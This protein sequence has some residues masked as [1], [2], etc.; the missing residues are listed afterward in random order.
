M[1]GIDLLREFGE[2]RSEAAFSEVVR[3]F[4]NLVYSVAHRRLGNQSLAQEVAQTVFIR[5]AES[6][7]KLHSDAELMGWL[8]RTTVHVSIDL[9]RSESRRRAREEQASAMQL[10]PHEDPSWK[11]IAPALDEAIN[12]LSDTDQQAILLRFFQDKSMR[13]L[14]GAIGITEDAAKMRVSRALERLRD[15]LSARGVTCTAVALGA[16]LLEHSMEAA[17]AEVSAAIAA[18]SYPMGAN[19]AATGTGAA[20]AALGAAKLAAGVAALILVGVSAWLVMG[21]PHA[22]KPISVGLA[23]SGALP[24]TN[25]P[26]AAPQDAKPA[27]DTAS[28]D[29]A[30]LLQAVIRARQGIASGSF[31]F[32]IE[33]FHIP[34]RETNQSRVAAV[35]DGAKRRFEQTRREYAYTYDPDPVKAEEIQAKADAFGADREAAIR[36]GLLSG[37]EAH[38]VSIYDGSALLHYRETD[39]KPESATVDDV[40]KGGSQFVFDPRCLG[41]RPSLSRASLED[42]YARVSGRSVQ[43]LDQELVAGSATWHLRVLMEQPLDLWLDLA[44]PTWV[45]KVQAGSSIATSRYEASAAGSSAIPV[46]VIHTD[47]REGGPAFGT[48][49]LQTASQL[50]TTVAPETFTLSGLGMK[51]GTSVSDIRIHRRIGYWTGTGLSENLPD[52]KSAAAEDQPSLEGML[53]VLDDN[54]PGSDAAFN[55][56]EWILLNTPD[57]PAVEKAAAVILREHVRRPDLASLCQGMAR[58]RHRCVG[59]LLGAILKE[60]P[61]REVRAVACFTLATLRKAACKYGQD[62]QLTAE[63]E[64]LFGQVISEFSQAGPIGADLSTKAR[65]ELSEL[66]R[67][68]IGKAAPDF[69][70]TDLQGQRLKLSEQRGKPVIVV[71]W[72]RSTFSNLDE[73]RHPLS[74]LDGSKFFWLGVY[75]ENRVGQG[76]DEF[77]KHEVPGPAI[78]DGRSGPIAQA[79][80]VQSW[81]TVFVLDRNGVIRARDSRGGDLTDAVKA[82]LAE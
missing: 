32:N 59:E 64:K 60:N 27:V 29:P 39:G 55:A 67:L 72:S 38:D 57:G 33:A 58:M 9:W 28:P 6:V 54:D 63:A 7:P 73:H 70:G 61:E 71:F 36:A 81:P 47:S 82:L 30:Q 80:N 21:R 22:G 46:E 75:C 74:A 18:Y 41:L 56:A 35:F 10:N 19:V 42:W 26:S 53:A 14:G 1:N 25:S 45:L 62:K 44:H 50:N 77:G 34:Q 79:W 2:K 24:A 52:K 48:H 4:T 68:T 5:L 31:N 13:E 49:L 37:F 15:Q 51:I 69:E 23:E 65:T 16:L 17:P 12:E 3:R 43:L 20:P 66:Q 40:S 8:H 11:S 78:F 76:A